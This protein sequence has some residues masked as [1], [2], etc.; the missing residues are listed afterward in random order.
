MRWWGAKEEWWGEMVG[1]G[2]KSHGWERAWWR[3]RGEWWEE[4]LM[5][6]LGMGE[7]NGGKG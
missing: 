5:G 3:W 2:G 1:L 6:L 7:V 4:I